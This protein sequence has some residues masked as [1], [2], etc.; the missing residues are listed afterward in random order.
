MCHEPTSRG[1]PPAIGVGKGTVVLEDFERAEAIF[2]IGQNTGT[3]SPRMMT[4]LVEARKRGIPI[5]A[6]NPMPER[7]LIRFTEP[8][9]VVQMATFGTTEIS[10]E[11]VHVRIGGDLAL[12]KGMMKVLFEREAAGEPVLDHGFLREHTTGMEAV[13]EE[14]LSLDW[15]DIVRVSGVAEEQIRRC[16]EIYVRSG[17]TIICYGMGLTQHQQGSRLVQ[18]VANLLFLRGNFGRPGAGI[19]P[20]RGH[21]NVQ[22]D[23]TVGIDEK[24][25]R[26]IWTGCA[27][28]SVSNRRARMATTPSSP[29]PR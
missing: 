11:F 1:L 6:V 15:A 2:V 26:R 28:C 10:S 9:D 14:I 8:Q 27:R 21:S 23:R 17:A 20:I 18:Q 4:H 13:R 24:Y 5:V 19:S 22:G 7:A 3:N 16:A 29:S 12:L 25:R